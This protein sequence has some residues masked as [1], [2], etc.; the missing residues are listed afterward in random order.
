MKLGLKYCTLVEVKVR[1]VTVNIDFSRVVCNVV[2]LFNCQRQPRKLQEGHHHQKRKAH[3]TYPHKTVP[4]TCLLSVPRPPKVP[5]LLTSSCPLREAQR[6]HPGGREAV[7]ERTLAVVECLTIW[8]L[9][10]I[11]HPPRLPQTAPYS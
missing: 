5:H 4:R 8:S 1:H 9:L 2:F 6:S 11:T 10:H 3:S 7:K